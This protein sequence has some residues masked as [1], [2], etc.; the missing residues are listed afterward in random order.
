SLAFY[1]CVYGEAIQMSKGKAAKQRLC[2]SA[3]FSK[4][5]KNEQRKS[6]EAATLRICM[7]QQATENEQR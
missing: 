1:F 5:E 3:W 2:E 6:C 7:V 4:M